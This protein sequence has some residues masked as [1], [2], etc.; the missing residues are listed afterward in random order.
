MG[1]FTMNQSGLIRSNAL[2]ICCIS[3][4]MSSVTLA[5]EYDGAFTESCEESSSAKAQFSPIVYSGAGAT[6]AS[7]SNVFPHIQSVAAP[8]L[9]DAAELHRNLSV[10][11]PV[12]LHKHDHVRCVIQA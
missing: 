2:L 11:P 3:M 8:T 12:T 9:G 6:M 7:H 1:N 4:L 10:G 5:E